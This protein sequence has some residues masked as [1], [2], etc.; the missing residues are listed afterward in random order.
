MNPKDRLASLEIDEMCSDHFNLLLT[1]IP[2][3]DA[4]Y[5]FKLGPTEKVCPLRRTL[6]I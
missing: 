5:L 2:R 4:V 3:Y 1:V 6:P